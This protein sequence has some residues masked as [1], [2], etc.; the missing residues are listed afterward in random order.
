METSNATYITPEQLRNM[1]KSKIASMTLLTG[2]IIII[3]NES[4]TKKDEDFKEENILNKNEEQKTNVEEEKKII[5]RTKKETKV[6]EGEDEKKVEE[7]VEIEV[8]AR[9]ETEKKEKEEVLRGPDG[10]ILLNDILTGG[11]AEPQEQPQ[12]NQEE[13]VNQQNNIT[14]PQQEMIQ[15]EIT[16]PEQKDEMNNNAYNEQQYPYEEQNNENV[17]YDPNAYSQEQQQ[18]YPS[19]NMDNQNANE[20]YVE[21]GY[22][23]NY[24]EQQDYSQQEQYYPQEGEQAEMYP[25]LDGNAN[26]QQYPQQEYQQSI[27]VPQEEQEYYQEE[28]QPQQQDNNQPITVPQGQQGYCSEEIQSEQKTV[29]QPVLPV[30][31]PPV[32]QPIQ[33]PSQVPVQPPIAQPQV[34]IQQTTGTKKGMFVPPQPSKFPKVQMKFGFNVPKMPIRKIPFHPHVPMIHRPHGPMIHPPHGPMIHPPHGPI[35]RPMGFIPPVHQKKVLINVGNKGIVKK[36]VYSNPIGTMM[37]TTKKIGLKN[38]KPIIYE[39]DVVKKEY[40]LRAR[41]KEV[42][43]EQKQALCPECA[44]EEYFAKC[45][46]KIETQYNND[47]N[48][49][50]ADNFV[51]HEIVETSDNSKSYVVARKGGITVSSDH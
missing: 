30:E 44:N 2:E 40:V 41:K 28:E 11:V 34:P 32:Q 27:N 6:E 26:D 22:D 12:I 10:K 39:N 13:N 17:T 31:Q 46:N 21:S 25:N 49:G 1:D 36:V 18:Y 4:Q 8:E 38:T 37:I 51:F 9:P 5:L 20:Q 3:S 48:T 24:Y 45:D 35:G 19:E 50:I 7:K 33:P 23:N 47:I 42:Y 43:D 14:L 29:E 15:P 16:V